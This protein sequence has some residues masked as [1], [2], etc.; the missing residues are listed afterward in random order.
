MEVRTPKRLRDVLSSKLEFDGVVE[1]LVENFEKYAAA[2]A[3]P[4]Y[5]HV[6]EP[7]ERKFIDK[8][9]PFTLTMGIE[10]PIIM[11]GKPVIDVSKEAEAL[12]K[13]EAKNN[14]T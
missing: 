1:L 13:W 5:V 11:E 12:R 7:D 8:S 2:A 4:Y 14:L 10:K 3:D 9:I 6:I